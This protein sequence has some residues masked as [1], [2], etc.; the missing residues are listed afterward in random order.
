MEARHDDFTELIKDVSDDVL[1]LDDPA[2]AIQHIGFLMSSVTTYRA[3]DRAALAALEYVFIRQIGK[4][5]AAIQ[6][7]DNK[8]E[9]ES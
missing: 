7:L 6:A 3:Q 8:S 4:N 9:C 5:E 2:N 1:N